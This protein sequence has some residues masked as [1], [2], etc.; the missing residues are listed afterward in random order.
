MLSFENVG[1][2]YGDGPETLQDVSFDVAPRSFQFLTGPSGA[3]TCRQSAI[4]GSSSRNM[5]REIRYPSLPSS[6]ASVSA[7]TRDPLCSGVP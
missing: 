2:R 3:A 1:L 5:A 7:A 4:F 6:A